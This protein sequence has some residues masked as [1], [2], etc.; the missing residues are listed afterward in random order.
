MPEA[1][2]IGRLGRWE[3]YRVGTVQRFEAGDKGPRAQVW[4]ELHPDPQRRKV[5][6]RC[7]QECRRNR[8]RIE[9][10]HREGFTAWQRDGL[11]SLAFDHIGSA[12]LQIEGR[13]VEQATLHR[14]R[15]A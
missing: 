13:S 6:D 12:P 15:F 7:G 2:S 8:E 9:T 14:V 3:G 10:L 4:I 11:N 1:E 5:C